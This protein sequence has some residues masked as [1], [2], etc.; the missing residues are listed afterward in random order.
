MDLDH[1][2]IV[3]QAK[4]HCRVP[5]CALR[6]LFSWLMPN[7]GEISGSDVGPSEGSAFLLTEVHIG[8]E[9]GYYDDPC[10][11][12]HLELQAAIVFHS[13]ELSIAWP[14]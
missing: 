14:P 3:G 5:L 7:P 9:G 13:Q 2:G 11:P 6:R 8:H 1:L 12:G 10:G 4:G